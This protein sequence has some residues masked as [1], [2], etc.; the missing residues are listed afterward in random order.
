MKVDLITCYCITNYI[1]LCINFIQWNISKK[2]LHKAGYV[3]NSE[4]KSLQRIDH[5]KLKYR[6]LNAIFGKV[7]SD[8]DICIIVHCGIKVRRCDML[9]KCGDLNDALNSDVYIRDKFRR[10]MTVRKN[11]MAL[12]YVPIKMRDY[13]MCLPIKWSG[14]WTDPAWRYVPQKIKEILQKPLW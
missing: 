10:N 8:I 13:D 12:R 9:V 14:K 6:D 5:N 2:K 11:N 3:I 4:Q 1:F 7:L